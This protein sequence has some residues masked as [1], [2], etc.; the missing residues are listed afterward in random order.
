[1]SLQKSAMNVNGNGVGV[2][3][4]NEEWQLLCKSHPMLR[5]E[6][7]KPMSRSE[8]YLRKRVPCAATAFSRIGVCGRRLD[9]PG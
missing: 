7:G 5:S 9:K 2:G 1:M 4:T 8:I 6:L 3:G